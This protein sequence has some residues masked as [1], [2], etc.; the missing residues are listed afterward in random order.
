ML[1]L[2]N[3]SP[4]VFYTVIVMLEDYVTYYTAH[5]L[6]R[7]VDVL[8]RLETVHLTWLVAEVFEKPRKVVWS[9]EASS[10][11]RATYALV[12]WR[13]LCRGVGIKRIGSR[14]TK[15]LVIRA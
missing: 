15:I 10:V 11:T 7:V 8:E 4:Q 3:A 13:W 14:M 6:Y 1:K 12:H 2:L 9:A 5:R